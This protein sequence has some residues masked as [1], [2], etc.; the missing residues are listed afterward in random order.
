MS[1]HHLL[2][3]HLL[4]LLQPQQPQQPQPPPTPSAQLSIPALVLG[5]VLQVVVMVLHLP[6]VVLL[7]LSI[8][9]LSQLPHPPHPHPEHPHHP[10]SP[11]A[12]T[13]LRLHLRSMVVPVVSP[14]APVP[15]LAPAVAT[16]LDVGGLLRRIV[17]GVVVGLVPGIGLHVQLP[18]LLLVFP[19]QALP[20]PHPAKAE[21]HLRLRLF[22]V[23]LLPSARSRRMRMHLYVL[24]PVLLLVLGLTQPQSQPW[25]PHSPQQWLLPPHYLPRPQFEP[26]P[27]QL[28][29]PHPSAEAEPGAPPHPRLPLCLPVPVLPVLLGVIVPLLLAQPLPVPFK[30]LL[31]LTTVLG[32]VLYLPG[33]VRVPVRV[34][35]FLVGAVAGVVVVGVV[36]PDL[37]ARVPLRVAVDMV[38]V[39]VVVG[40]GVVRP[41]QL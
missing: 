18:V 40:V 5:L 25:L 33:V 7:G 37:L 12:P 24:L 27:L 41:P 9:L 35:A 28:Q 13:R 17:R 15:H 8:L 6:V 20:P 38:I 2:K 34:V 14:A 3:H 30:A 23:V 1:Q 19:D 31:L 4:H 39:G 22:F 16:V 10:T 32:A 29:P 36:R 11:S 21:H 26:Q